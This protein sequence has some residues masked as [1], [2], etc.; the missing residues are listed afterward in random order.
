MS[1]GSGASLFGYYPH[2][3]PHSHSRISHSDPS[4]NP[5]S[6]SY[7]DS[8]NYSGSVATGGSVSAGSYANGSSSHIPAEYTAS[9]GSHDQVA[10]GGDS[11]SGSSKRPFPFP[12]GT[13]ERDKRARSC[14]GH[15][16][17]ASGSGSGVVRNGMW[18]GSGGTWTQ[19]RAVPEGGEASGSGG[20]GD[21]RQDV[22]VDEESDV[23]SSIG[24]AEIDQDE[25][26]NQESASTDESSYASATELP[27]PVR[28]QSPMIETPR[29]SNT[30]P[31][32]A[33][34]TYTRPTTYDPTAFSIDA[35]STSYP[36]EPMTTTTLNRGPS[37]APRIPTPA[38]L[39]SSSP[40]ELPIL[41]PTSSST[42]TPSIPAFPN[43]RTLSYGVRDVH[44]PPRLPPLR[45]PSSSGLD[46]LPPLSM[47]ALTGA[48]V[49]SPDELESAGRTRP[50][51]MWDLGWF[52]REYN[53]ATST[54]A[55]A[56]SA[57][58][59]TTSR[60]PESQPE[61]PSVQSRS[62]PGNPNPTRPLR[63]LPGT[64]RVASP[65]PTRPLTVNTGLGNNN[66]GSSSVDSAIPTSAFSERRMPLPRVDLEHD[67][68]S[69]STSSGFV[70]A[71][72][73]AGFV[74]GGS[75]GFAGAS[76]GFAGASSGFARAVSSRFAAAA[77]SRAINSGSSAVGSDEATSPFGSAFSPGL[78]DSLSPIVNGPASPSFGGLASPI[79]AESV[80]STVQSD[81]EPNPGAAE[82]DR[83]EATAASGHP[84]SA[85]FG[86][87]STSGSSASTRTTPSAYTRRPP[88]L[89]LRG[90]PTSPTF[91]S[92]SGPVSA[93][94][95]FV[96]PE[97]P[98]FPVSASPRTSTFDLAVTP[99][100][101]A[102]P[103]FVARMMEVDSPVRESGG[104]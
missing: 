88:S 17:G 13:Q 70:G 32:S 94:A 54:Q 78:D 61:L 85:A 5:S 89:S 63:A 33:A 9:T 51:G 30:I 52:T 69:E 42:S 23:D 55:P 21:S 11:L 56:S 10:S 101:S 15:G 25:A 45:S 46:R 43:P 103:S 67:W 65:P 6:S 72:S 16:A 84:T 77:S 7:L 57:S 100:G 26:P 38:A 90:F 8:N 98:T 37:P 86:S 71:G 66:F 102:L 79:G 4:Y 29:Q 34:T 104:K 97:S 60:P 2:P 1:G 22:R 24:D 58:G 27:Q 68:M 76:S 53:E 74:G 19:A 75:S 20:A 73:S 3:H 64:R 44:P 95:S 93:A 92:M 62:D 59:I 96:L 83:V 31:F 48:E 49:D 39:R 40:L 28:Q 36:M 50:G 99:P 87:P 12:L 41:S 14:E 35:T 47:H 91:S 81:D 82:H 18:E 80:A